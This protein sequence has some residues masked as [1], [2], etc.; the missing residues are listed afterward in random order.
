MD[1]EKRFPWLYVILGIGFLAALCIG[2]VLVGGGAAYLLTMRSSSAVVTDQ[3]V[4]VTVEVVIP[5]STQL[6]D[7]ELTPLEPTSTQEPTPEATETETIPEATQPKPTPGPTEPEPTSPG[8]PLTGDQRLDEY[9]MFDDFSSDALGWPVYDDGTTIIQYENQAYSFQITEPDY[10]DWAYFPVS[11]IPYEIR[12]EVQGLEGPQDGTFGVFC[13]YQDEDN[14][15]YAE[16]DLQDSTYL[17]GENLNGENIP[18]TPENDSGNYWQSTNALNPPQSI[19]RL[20]VTCYLDGITLYINDQLVAETS[21][22]QPFAQTGVAA[23]F[24]YAYDFAGENGYK[25]FFDNVDVW[26]PVQ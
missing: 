6:P 4:N 10:Y 15:Y 7:V 11:F 19:N 5:T 25:V 1:E 13:Q 8:P 14:Y 23:F 20:G 9:S 2:V 24:V 26:E 17:L 22:P 3:V 16:F 12:F 21:V 18:L